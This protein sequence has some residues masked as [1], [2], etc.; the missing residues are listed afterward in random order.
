[1]GAGDGL[2][3]GAERPKATA[4]VLEARVENTNGDLP[5][6]VTAAQNIARLGEPDVAARGLTLAPG[7]SLRTATPRPGGQLAER[8]EGLHQFPNPVLSFGRKGFERR[9][10]AFRLG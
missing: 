10:K 9:S 2:G 6:F 7:R 5:A 1:M 4:L 8:V 3:D